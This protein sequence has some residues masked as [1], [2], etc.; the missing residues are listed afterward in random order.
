QPFHLP[1][2]LHHPHRAR[3]PV[4]LP[5]HHQ[6]APLRIVLVHPEPARA[7]LEL[8]Q[9]S[10]PPPRLPVHQPLGLAVRIF[11][12][13]RL[14]QEPQLRGHRAEEPHHAHLVHGRMPQPA[15]IDRVPIPVA[16]TPPALPLPS[17]LALGPHRRAAWHRQPAVPQP[18]AVPPAHL[19]RPPH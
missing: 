10:L 1:L 11:H 17:R 18:I 7:V 9:A 16:G 19:S 15:D 13:H 6:V 4:V 2:Q 14:D 8:D 5:A 12:P 3:G